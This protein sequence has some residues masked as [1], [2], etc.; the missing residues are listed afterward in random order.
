MKESVWEFVRRA[1]GTYAVIHNGKLVSDCIP[2][3]RRQSEF[4][5]RFGFCGE[6]YKKIVRQLEQTDNC[7]VVI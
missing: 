6:E 7:T 1:D 4:C 3:Q 2:E 5:V